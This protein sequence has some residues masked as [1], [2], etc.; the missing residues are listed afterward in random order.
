MESFSSI[1]HSKAC[2]WFI[3][4]ECKW[5]RSNGGEE[6]EI[7]GETFLN[8]PG[9]NCLVLAPLGLTYILNRHFKGH[10]E[11]YQLIWISNF[12]LSVVSICLVFVFV[13]NLFF[14]T[15]QTTVPSWVTFCWFLSTLLGALFGEQW[16]S[17][18]E[19]LLDSHFPVIISQLW[20]TLR[21]TI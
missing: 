9:L 17:Y 13:F 7:R 8:F 18:S 12:K 19:Y 6:V 2:L 16:N 3:W 14:S 20:P 5:G 21:I 1:C 15:T 11:T 10:I 4:F